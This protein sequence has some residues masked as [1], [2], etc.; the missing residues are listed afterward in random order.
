[1]KIACLTRCICAS[2][3]NIYSNYGFGGLP[4]A[5]AHLAQHGAL[6]FVKVKAHGWALI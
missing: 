4:D 1:M 5:H 2:S 6:A 3:Y